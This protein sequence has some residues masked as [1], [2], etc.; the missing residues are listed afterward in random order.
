MLKS[1]FKPLKLYTFTKKKIMNKKAIL[2]LELAKKMY[3]GDDEQL[4]QFA[5]ENYPELGDI[6]SRIKTFEDA[7]RELK[8][9][10]DYPIVLTQGTTSDLATKI[11]IGYKLSII[12]ATLNQGWQAD[13]S[14]EEYKWFPYFV[15][16]KTEKGL[17]FCSSVYNYYGSGVPAHHC[18]KSKILSDYAGKQFIN[19]YKEYHV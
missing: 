15:Y 6:T 11:M 17:R 5:L 16:D 2:S 10:S 18:F 12:A 7:C 1:L 13:W 19:L 4:K 8:I 9:S 14:N 3:S